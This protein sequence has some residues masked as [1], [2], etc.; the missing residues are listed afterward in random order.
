VNL[1]LLTQVR[2]PTSLQ[3]EWQEVEVACY[4]S[5]IGGVTV[6]VAEAV[7]KKLGV[8]EEK[9]STTDL[10]DWFAEH[11]N[12]PV[13]AEGMATIPVINRRQDPP[14]LDLP[15]RQSPEVPLRYDLTKLPILVVLPTSTNP[16]HSG[17]ERR[18][19]EYNDYGLRFMLY[20]AW[21]DQSG[22]TVET[23]TCFFDY[24]V[25]GEGQLYVLWSPFADDFYTRHYADYARWG[26]DQPGKIM[27]ENLWRLVPVGGEGHEQWRQLNAY[28]Q[29]VVNN[30]E[31]PFRDQKFLEITRDI[32]VR[33]SGLGWIE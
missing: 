26:W 17:L 2:S 27:L 16:G 28:G 4:K 9:G 19:A 11:S 18:L 6:L 12:V 1:Q 3:P 22:E 5:K 30:D 7:V 8:L 24:F 31:D 21:R 29:V 14:E 32:E 20:E 25:D 15:T 23:D 10:A 33:W 13:D